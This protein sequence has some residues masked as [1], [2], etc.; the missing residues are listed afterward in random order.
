MTMKKTDLVKSLAKKIDGR[1]KSRGVPTRFGQGAAAA[2]NPRDQE[3]SPA[4]PVTLSCRLP[5]ELVRQLR[6]RA[7]AQEGGVNA[8]LAQALAQWLKDAAAKKP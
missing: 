4:K 6:E 3:T 8:I 5:A 7:T 1:M 2:L